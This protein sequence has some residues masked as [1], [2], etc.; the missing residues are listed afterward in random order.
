MFSYIK[1]ILISK[2]PNNAVVEAF[3]LG[4]DAQVS[5]NTFLKLPNTGSEVKLFLELCVSQD[6]VSL[7]GFHSQEEKT[8]FLRLISIS[9]IGP[10]GATVILSGVELT[11]LLASIVTGDAKA[12]SK[13]KGVGK[14]TAELIILELKEKLLKEM[15]E[16]DGF[17]AGETSQAKTA[18]ALSE[19]AITALM[20]LGITRAEAKPA[21][22][23]ARA[24]AKTI[25]ELISLSLRKLRQ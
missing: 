11:S 9:G 12:L 1:G 10:K 21:V 14:K 4:Y 7:F 23:K 13:I 20:T 16:A 18:D 25:E 19:S 17:F 15:P 2:S 3:G 8:M 22:E 5:Y 24:D 6:G